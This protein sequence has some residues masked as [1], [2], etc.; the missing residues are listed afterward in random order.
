MTKKKIQT[1]PLALE[2]PQANEVKQE[3]SAEK[4]REEPKP[5][6]IQTTKTITCPDC[7]KNML[8]K[9][10]KYYHSLKCHPASISAKPPGSVAQQSEPVAH[11]VVDFGFNQRLQARRD[12]YTNL[13][14]RAT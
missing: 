10:F 3:S 8:E 13:L 1:E 14:S 7:K 6:K 11:H 2:E 9:T 4:P 12:K 5:D